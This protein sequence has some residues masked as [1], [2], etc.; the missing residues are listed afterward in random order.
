[1]KGSFSI[2][3]EKIRDI[4]ILLDFPADRGLGRFAVV[5]PRHDNG[6]GRLRHDLVFQGFEKPFE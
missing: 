3:E 6:F 2:S 4:G 5:V 1:M